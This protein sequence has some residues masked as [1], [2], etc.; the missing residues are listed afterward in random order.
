MCARKIFGRMACNFT[1]ADV[2][3]ECVKREQELE[4]AGL[5]AL[6]GGKYISGRVGQ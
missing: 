2:Q 4:D 6:D 5:L 1:E 3:A